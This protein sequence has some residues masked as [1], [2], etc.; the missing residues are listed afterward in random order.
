MPPSSRT[1]SHPP[2]GLVCGRSPVCVSR[3]VSSAQTCDTH[4]CVERQSRSASQATRHLLSTAHFSGAGQSEVNV[5]SISSTSW[6]T[7]PVANLTQRSPRSQSFVSL[8]AE[9]HLPNV[10]ERG[11]TQ[12]L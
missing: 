3:S 2:L 11:F 5:H 4:F 12:S 10:H 9:W 7:L 6:Q 8:Q 1:P